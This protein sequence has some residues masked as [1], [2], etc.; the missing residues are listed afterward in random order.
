VSTPINRDDLAIDD[1][2]HDHRVTRLRAPP[3]TG[4]A[5][6]KSTPTALRPITLCPYGSGAIIAAALVSQT[7]Q[8]GR[9]WEKL[10]VSV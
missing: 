6:L 2:T 5:P 3:N 10:N 7:M 1:L 8:R 4:N 9:W